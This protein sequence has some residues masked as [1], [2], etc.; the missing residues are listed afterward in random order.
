M[1]FAVALSL[2]TGLGVE[3]ATGSFPVAAQVVIGLGYTYCIGLLA[4]RAVVS[5][6]IRVR[7][8]FRNCR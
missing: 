3:T 6:F 2:L 5:L 7:D 8:K 1:G 4:K